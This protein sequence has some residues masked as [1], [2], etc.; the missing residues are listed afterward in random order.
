MSSDFSRNEN[1][2][3]EL[4]KDAPDLEQSVLDDVL[5][6][7][8]SS[9]VALLQINERSHQAFLKV[10]RQYTGQELTLDPVAIALVQAVLAET[11]NGRIVSEDRHAI[12]ASEIAE[13]LVT[14]PTASARL[15]AF[16]NKL[17]EAVT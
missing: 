8:M 11:L 1:Y 2:Y 15:A 16:W 6:A 9:D 13:S 10:A 7:T 17:Q 4:N 14:N 3:E 12:M 5:K